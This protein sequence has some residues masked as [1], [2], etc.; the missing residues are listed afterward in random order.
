MTPRERLIISKPHGARR[1]LGDTL[2]REHGPGAAQRTL[3]HEDPQTTA[4]AYQ[5]IDASDLAEDVSDVFED[6]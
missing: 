6:G 2:Y 3:R 1:G 5:H 4:K